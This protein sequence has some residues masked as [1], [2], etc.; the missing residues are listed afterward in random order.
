METKFLLIADC[1]IKEKD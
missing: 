1:K